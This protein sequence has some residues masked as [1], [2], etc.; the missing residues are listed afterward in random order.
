MGPSIADI[1]GQVEPDKRM[2]LLLEVAN[3]ILDD[4]PKLT[5]VALTKGDGPPIGYLFRVPPMPEPEPQT[6]EDR[7]AED[8]RRMA[9]LDDALTLDEMLAV[10][11][12][13]AA[14]DESQQS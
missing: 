8:A 10:L 2:D 11:D 1:V 13:Q 6:E 4:H 5:P 14:A 7:R 3:R 9:N 12:F